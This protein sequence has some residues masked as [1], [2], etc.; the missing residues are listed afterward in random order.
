MPEFVTTDSRRLQ[1]IL[2]NLL[3]NAIKFSKEDGT[4]ELRVA[5]EEGVDAGEAPLSMTLNESVSSTATSR[6]PFHRSA[7]SE[8][9]GDASRCPFGRSSF[10]APTTKE[11][12]RILRFVVRDCGK[13]IDKQNFDRIFQPFLQANAETERL[14]GG[15]GLG[16]A[17]TR[18][19][20]EGMNG[21]ISVN[22]DE[23]SW[24]EFTV[25]FA[26][27]DEPAKRDDY[28]AKMTDS[29]VVMICEKPEIVVTVSSILAEY[30]VD[31][32]VLQ[33]MS[34]LK[35]YSSNTHRNVLLIDEEVYDETTVVEYKERHSGTVPTLTFGPKYC[36][37]NSDVHFRELN[38][39]LPSVLM[40]T[41]MEVEKYP[42]TEG[43]RSGESSSDEA[44]PFQDLRV[45]IAE[46]N[47]INQ[48]VLQRMLTRLG[49]THVR[50]V[51]NGKDAVEAEAQESFDV[52]LMD[53]HMP[54]MNG[55]DACGLIQQREIARS[56]RHALVVFVTAHVSASFEAECAQAG[57][58]GFLQKPCSIHD[59]EK[60][61]RKVHAALSEE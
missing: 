24:S 37:K 55:I 16:L 38:Q 18:K 39:V 35:G 57:S 42:D 23:K 34:F 48:K 6:C 50:M 44:P 45:L 56:H 14:Y 13:G 49:M 29:S 10:T 1:Q 5:L 61:F 15:T 32:E 17:I 31:H 20:V 7:P 21:K 19:L 22:S 3:G 27:T 36:V 52:V 53:M 60:C 54:I 43:S 30:G 26:Y 8:D 25:D 28:G 9:S 46:D 11:E 47:L 40:R 12:K 2:Y 41:I 4:V 58:F 59:I 33:S 51:G